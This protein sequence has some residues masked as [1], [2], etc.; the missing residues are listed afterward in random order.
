[1]LLL[2]VSPYFFL[3]GGKASGAWS[4][5]LHVVTRLRMR[6]VIPILPL[7]AFMAWIAKTSVYHLH[8]KQTILS[9]YRFTFLTLYFISYPHLWSS[10]SSTAPLWSPHI[11]HANSERC[12]LY[13]T[14]H[15]FFTRCGLV[16]HLGL[17]LRRFVLSHFASTPLANLHHFLIYILSFSV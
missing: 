17:V 3:G 4:C 12:S 9:I 11:S 6:G 5:P 8:D 16:V 1:V 14:L 10:K 15:K 13:F 7:Y 2:S